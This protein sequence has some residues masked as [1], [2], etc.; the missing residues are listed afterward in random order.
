MWRTS[1]EGCAVDG[2]CSARLIRQGRHVVSRALAGTDAG[3]TASPDRSESCRRTAA[4]GAEEV[5]CGFFASEQYLDTK[6][7][8][9][10]GGGPN[11]V[12]QDVGPW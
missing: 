9:R 6:A 4:A 12:E 7:G 3:S 10:T 11:G 5:D 8:M 2:V 1:A